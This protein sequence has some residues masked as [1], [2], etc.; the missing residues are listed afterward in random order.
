MPTENRHGSNPDLNLKRFTKKKEAQK[1]HLCQKIDKRQGYIYIDIICL[2]F[3]DELNWNSRLCSSIY[4][5]H[6]KFL[7]SINNT[8]PAFLPF[9]FKCSTKKTSFYFCFKFGK[10]CGTRDVLLNLL[11]IMVKSLKFND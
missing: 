3:P 10:T 9:S 2:M 7:P 1:F 8:P 5:V 11:L 6:P 4:F